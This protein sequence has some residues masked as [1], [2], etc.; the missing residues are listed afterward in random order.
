LSIRGDI[1]LGADVI[2]GFPTETDEMFQNTYNMI[3]EL[4]IM[5]LHVFPYSIRENTPAARMPQVAGD[6][7]KFRAKKL[8]ELK[9]E[10]LNKHLTKKIGKTETILAES[11]KHG[12][13]ED[14]C[15]VVCNQQLEKGLLHTVKI[16]SISNGKLVAL[17]N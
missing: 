5:H 2:A 3:K 16:S 4:N 7:I 15:H 9:N 10:L 1:V 14:Y 6:V 11:H 17:K 13:T 8:R 12:Y